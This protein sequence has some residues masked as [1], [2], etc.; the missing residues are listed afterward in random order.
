M[1]T[2]RAF[3]ELAVRFVFV[4]YHIFKN[5]GT[6]LGTAT[7]NASGQ[8]TFSTS[9]LRVGTHTITASYQGNTDFTTSKGRLKDTVQQAAT[10]T[11]LVS[12]ASSLVSGQTVT[13]T[14]SVAGI[15]PA[16][17]TPSGKVIFMD[18]N[19][20]LR[21][22]ALDA[23]GRATYSTSAL[24]VGRHTI[25]AAYLGD[26][27]FMAS[28]SQAMSPVV[29]DVASPRKVDAAFTAFATASPA[30]LRPL[31]MAADLVADL[32]DNADNLFDTLVPLSADSPKRHPNDAALLALL[33]A[34]PRL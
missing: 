17:G 2:E 1:P 16:S 33:D 9:A 18:G 22:I 13:L 26:M 30:I 21:T 19:K 7:L 3:N 23:D 32:S 4:H 29:I 24:R 11:T 31:S 27:D 5:G 28:I 25:T 14:A 34:E 20:I 6:T 12:T 8:A 10:N 15:A